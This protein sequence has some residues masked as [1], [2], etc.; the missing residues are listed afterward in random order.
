M[1]MS[2]VR[3]K[4][5]LEQ[6]EYQALLKLSEQELRNPVEQTRFILRQELARRGLLFLSDVCQ[7][8]DIPA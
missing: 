6:P 3:I 2:A 8:E 1:T 7:V 5:L 4:L